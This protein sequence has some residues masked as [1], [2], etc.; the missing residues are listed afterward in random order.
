MPWLLLLLFIALVAYA[1]LDFQ[2]WL[3]GG[4][5][6][7]VTSPFF[8]Y[9]GAGALGALV[10]CMLFYNAVWNAAMHQLYLDDVAKAED[11]YRKRRR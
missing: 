4:V 8:P 11:T 3:A 6:A 9:V 7:L 5:Q 2:Y 1:P 10:V